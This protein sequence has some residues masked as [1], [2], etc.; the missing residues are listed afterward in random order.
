MVITRLEVSAPSLELKKKSSFKAK[1]ITQS[2]IFLAKTSS[3]YELL[4]N[5]ELERYGTK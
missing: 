3:Y 5:L 2:S 1:I 4:N